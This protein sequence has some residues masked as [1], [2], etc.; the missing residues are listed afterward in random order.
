[1]SLGFQDL[2]TV[3]FTITGGGIAQLVGD[4]TGGPG[5]GT[6]ST[7]VVSVGG[8][9]AANIHTAELLVNTPE[10][11]NLVLAGPISGAA[12]APS[13]R[14]LDPLDIPID[15]TT[16]TISGSNKIQ[17]SSMGGPGFGVVAVPIGTNPTAT[18]PTDTLTF[19]SS[20][21]VDITG[22]SITNTINL[23]FNAAV[24]PLIVDAIVDNTTTI[25]NGSNQIEA[26]NITGTSNG[27]LTTLSALSL[28]GSQVSGD[29]SGNAAN[30][31]GVVAL[32]NGGTGTA[33]ASAN[34]AF[35]ALSPMTT[36]GDIIYENATPVGSRLAGNTTTTKKFLTQTGTGTISAPPSWGTIAAID[37]PTLNQNTSGTASNVTGTVLVANGG[38]GDT[39]LTAYAVL[40]GGTTST[41]AVQSIASVGTTGQILTSN[42][43][44]ALPTFQ[45]APA[46]GINQ[47][48]GD[49]TAGPGT[50]SQAASVVKVNGASVPLSKT[51]VGTN[52]SG[53]IVDASSASLSNNTSGTAANI[54]ATSN[55]SL[56]TLSSLSLPVGQVSGISA[57]LPVTYTA[58]VIAVNYDNSSV[59]LNGSNQL[60]V[61]S[62]QNIL[63][64]QCFS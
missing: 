64:N 26:I 6:V 22:N 45:A 50:G 10:G 42:G 8:S 62:G 38:T 48:T 28:P 2:P 44:G 61:Q 5:S 54:T 9:T 34:A 33:A 31:T 7:T 12:A 21:S 27:T 14:K 63:M 1:M 23:D 25:N 53:Q 52:G 32:V 11:D 37:V 16:L 55:S 35:N 40:C 47:L 39:S 58:G 51:I 60:Q 24:I 36:L 4:V 18:I 57:T 49:V 30:V 20:G 3:N 43:P 19:T 29:I 46:G 15:G 41:A 17:A 13:F 59:T 56:T